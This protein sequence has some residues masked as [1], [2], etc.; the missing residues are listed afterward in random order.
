MKTTRG[1]GSASVFSSAEKSISIDNTLGLWQC[2]REF[3]HFFG[4]EKQHLRRRPGRANP[5]RDLEDQP[6][7]VAQAANLRHADYVRV[8]CGYLDQL[9]MD[10][11]E[12][13]EQALAQATPL[14]RSNRDSRLQKLICARLKD[15]NRIDALRSSPASYKFTSFVLDYW[16]ATNHKSQPIDIFNWK[17]RRCYDERRLKTSI[18]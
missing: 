10:F 18:V 17:I 12:L 4:T 6:A 9:A 3:Q 7:Q 14:T 2:G 1:E 13:D 15:E 16:K 5:G 11:A 8:L